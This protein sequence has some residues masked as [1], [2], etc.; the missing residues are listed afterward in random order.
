MPTWPAPAQLQ[1]NDFGEEFEPGVMSTTMESGPKKVI[2]VR[3]R[4]MVSRPCTVKFASRTDYLAFIAWFQTTL[5]N[6]ALWF[7][8]FDPV[9]R[10]TVQARIADGKLGKARPLSGLTAPGPW[11]MPL[12]IE[13]WQ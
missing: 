4:V 12:T 2:Q 1:F 3:S 8:W 6:G 9:R 11:L 10:V 5:K 7:D 13:T